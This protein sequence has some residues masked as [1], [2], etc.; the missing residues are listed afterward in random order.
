M[1]YWDP[2]QPDPDHGLD[3]LGNVTWY[4]DRPRID[5]TVWPVALLERIVATPA[6]P[7]EL[8]AGY[9]ILLDKD[10]LVARLHQPSFTAFVPSPPDEAAYL[11]TVNDFFVDAPAVA[12]GL[13]RGDL[14]PA[15]WVLDCDMRHLYLL[16]MLQWR[17]ECDRDW[18]VPARSLG[19]GL[20]KALPGDLWRELEAT[21]AG[22]GTDHH[23][24]ELYR[25]IALF[26]RVARDVGHRLGYTYPE[27]LDER[28]MAYVSHLH[29]AMLGQD[30]WRRG[31]LFHDQSCRS[32]HA[33]CS[34]HWCR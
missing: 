19:K 20:H 21:Y 3:Y 23:W 34:R 7:A 13:A 6:L 24:E 8:D 32:R 25:T 29:A 11:E 12:I 9:R 2:V 14:L 15:R 27:A 28:V 16:R 30:V 5:F 17:M 33:G 26:R 31:D 4:V 18:Q 1:V 10:G 22:A